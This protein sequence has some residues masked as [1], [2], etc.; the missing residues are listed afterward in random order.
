MTWEHWWFL[1]KETLRP[2]TG[3]WVMMF[4][5]IVIG[6]IMIA[7]YRGKTP[8]FKGAWGELGRRWTVVGLTMIILAL[9]A[10]FSSIYYY[11]AYPGS[12]YKPY[13]TRIEEKA[14]TIFNERD[15]NKQI[16]DLAGYC[17]IE[18]LKKILQN[19][20]KDIPKG[21]RQ[22]CVNAA[23]ATPWTKNVTYSYDF[24]NRFFDSL[25]WSDEKIEEF[26]KIN[27]AV[28]GVVGNF[29]FSPEQVELYKNNRLEKLHESLSKIQWTYLVDQLV[30][31]MNKE[32]AIGFIECLV[33]GYGKD[34]DVI[35]ALTCGMPNAKEDVQKKGLRYILGDMPAGRK[36]AFLSGVPE[37]FDIFEFFISYYNWLRELP[38]LLIY[39]IAG[40]VMLVSGGLMIRQGKKPLLNI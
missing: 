20:V 29:S 16:Q 18:T 30:R 14:D 28:P 8:P 27:G 9:I 4:L 24:G 2:E 7:Y 38:Y 15:A 17:E 13:T 35:K 12:R 3:T 22:K 26:K 32:E 11:T 36:C 34:D 33:E 10:Y 40:I 25:Y 5:P 6:L 39:L 19:V 21:K 1:T 23:L 37:E 31:P